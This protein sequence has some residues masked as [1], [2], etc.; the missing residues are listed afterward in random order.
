[1]RKIFVAGN[2]LVEEDKLA[3]VVAEN[4]GTRGVADFEQIDS[5]S[6]LENIPKEFVLLDVAEGITK[7]EKMGLDKL[8]Q[9][10]PVSSHDFDLGTELLLYKK[11][12]KIGPVII[13]A[14][15]I[16]YELEKALAEVEEIIKSL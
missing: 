16:G 12:G 3:L 14:V 4:L 13:I 11:L 5:L 6:S 8:G 10:K 2:R 9:L 1:M 7:V 15:P